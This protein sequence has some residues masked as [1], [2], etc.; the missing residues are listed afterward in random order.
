MKI[1]KISQKNLKKAVNIIKAGG[2]VVFPTDTVYG[3]ACDA[4]N[5][6]AIKKLFKI[7]QRDD[8]KPLPIF[9]K[10][11]KMAKDLALISKSQEKFL[12][13][14]WPGKLTAV[15]KRKP[16]V[17]IYGIDK[18]TIAIRIPSYES[19]N[20]LL[21]EI[22]L[23]LT[24]TSANISDKP[25]SVKIRDVIKQFK[26]EKNQPDLIIDAGNL[27]KSLPSTITDLTSRKIKI[28]REGEAKING[29]KINQKS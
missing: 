7:K 17:K 23:P 8:K 18:K 10:D 26:E 27:K 15:L 24:G 13:K 1:S 2:V 29:I 6:K 25:A 21:K 28:I 11:F 4:T 12:K 16:G 9:V 3:L 22:D 19:I 20:I 5:K 14:Y